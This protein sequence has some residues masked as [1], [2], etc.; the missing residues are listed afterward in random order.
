M[1]VKLVVELVTL[2]IVLVCLAAAATGPKPKW[3]IPAQ[4]W[5]ESGSSAR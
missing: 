3:H 4:S 1:R 2:A 5:D